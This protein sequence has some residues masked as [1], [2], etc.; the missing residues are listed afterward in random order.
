MKDANRPTRVQV[1]HEQKTYQQT[2]DLFRLLARPTQCICSLLRLRIEIIS[3]MLAVRPPLR[4]VVL[5]MI[6][7]GEDTFSCA[8]VLASKSL[9]AR[10]NHHHHYHSTTDNKKNSR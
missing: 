1:P 7:D 10:G 3:L 5:A 2:N 9:H 4:P 6:G 8:M